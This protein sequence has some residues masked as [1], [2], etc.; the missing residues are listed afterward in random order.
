MKRYIQVQYVIAFWSA[1]LEPQFLIFLVIYFQLRFVISIFKNPQLQN[2]QSAITNAFHLLRA[3]TG[4]ILN[5]KRYED[6]K[7]GYLVI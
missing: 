3:N 6:T 1:I 5:V 2:A 4:D 7:L